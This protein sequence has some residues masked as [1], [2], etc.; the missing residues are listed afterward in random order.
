MRRRQIQLGC[1][2]CQLRNLD[3]S[4][5]LAEARAGA[6]RR[7]MQFV[8]AGVGAEPNWKRVHRQVH[9]D[10]DALVQRM[11][12]RAGDADGINVPRVHRRPPPPSLEA[13]AA[14]YPE[15]DAAWLAVHYTGE[16]SYADIA[17]RFSFHFTM[18]G[19]VAGGAGAE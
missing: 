18:V 8:A 13:I 1:A 11:Q 2:C 17:G 7:H 16:Y 6:R 4:A 3:G 9:L 5:G 19:Q 15:R 14:P 12:A 10:S